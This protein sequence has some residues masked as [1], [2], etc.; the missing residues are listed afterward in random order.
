MLLLG[1]AAPFYH[2]SLGLE[3]HPVEVVHGSVSTVGIVG[4]AIV[5]AGVRVPNVVPDMSAHRPRDGNSTPRRTQYVQ[6]RSIRESTSGWASR[7]AS[8]SRS[9]ST[10]IT[11]TSPRRPP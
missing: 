10:L 1:S 5:V 7:S 2:P 9:P 3:E 11:W 4:I 8:T 6:S